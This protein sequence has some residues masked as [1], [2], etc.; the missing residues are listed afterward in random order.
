MKMEWDSNSEAILEQT[1]Q[2]SHK[3]SEKILS[4]GQILFS[5]LS[6]NFVGELND[7]IHENK[8][9]EKKSDNPKES[10]AAKKIKKLQSD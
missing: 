7:K 3:F 9:R 4:I 10:S 2:N 5:T 6:K 1:C 8:K